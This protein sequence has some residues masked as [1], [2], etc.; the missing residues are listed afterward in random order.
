M[1]KQKVSFKN[2]SKDKAKFVCDFCG[3]PLEELWESPNEFEGQYC[4][5]HFRLM[6]ED[7]EE[8]DRWLEIFG[9]LGD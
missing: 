9:G 5:E 1:S 3:K 8:F 2:K 7:I 4:F 6:H